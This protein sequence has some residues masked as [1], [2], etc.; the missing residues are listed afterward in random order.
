MAQVE[1][2]YAGSSDARGN[3]IWGCSAVGPPVTQD[4]DLVRNV[5]A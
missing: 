5:A 3:T 1:V 4:E 2:D